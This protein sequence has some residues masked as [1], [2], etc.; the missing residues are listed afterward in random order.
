MKVSS[1]LITITQLAIA[2]S[3]HVGSPSADDERGTIDATKLASSSKL[4]ERD[5]WYG[6]PYGCSNDGYCYRSC[7]SNGEWC[8][9][10]ASNG[11]GAWL[12]CGN[13][14]QCAPGNTGDAACGK[15]DCDACG[16]SC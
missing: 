1:I 7:G 11:N 2:V 12:T 9:L 8:W 14:D 13:A 15:G 3:G 6:A 4:M 10:A 16:C 5:C